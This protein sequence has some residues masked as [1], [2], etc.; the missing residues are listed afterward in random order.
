MWSTVI[1]ISFRVW[2]APKE[3]NVVVLELQSLYAG[4]LPISAQSLLDQLAELKRPHP[5][6]A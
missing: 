4:A 6:A 2:V 3:A 5:P 1:S